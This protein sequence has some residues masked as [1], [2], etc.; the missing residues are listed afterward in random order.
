[1]TDLPSFRVSGQRSGI[2]RYAY[3]PAYGYPTHNLEEAKADA[4]RMARTLNETVTLIDDSYRVVDHYACP[5]DIVSKAP[6][7]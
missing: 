3:G 4:R 1:M 5:T 6:H 7:P 2:C